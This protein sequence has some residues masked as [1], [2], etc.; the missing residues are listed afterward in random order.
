MS[1][2]GTKPDEVYFNGARYSWRVKYMDKQQLARAWVAYNGYEKCVWDNAL[3]Q[4][5]FDEHY[6]ELQAKHGAIWFYA[7]HDLFGKPVFVTDMLRDMGIEFEVEFDTPMP[8]EPVIT[9]NSH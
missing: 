4:S 2:F 3:P 1:D 9:E 7:D 8:D 6:D 5:W